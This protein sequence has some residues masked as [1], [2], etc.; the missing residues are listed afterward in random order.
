[1]GG[2]QA[3]AWTPG[4][5]SFP[6]R[7]PC[8][9]VCSWAAGRRISDLQIF[10]N[11]QIV[12]SY[13]PQ[14]FMQVFSLA[15]RRSLCYEYNFCSCSLWEF[16]AWIRADNIFFVFHLPSSLE[17]GI[18]APPTSRK[19]K[20]GKAENDPREPSE[21]GRRFGSSCVERFLY[22]LGG[23]LLLW[24]REFFDERGFLFW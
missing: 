13:L 10:F 2:V 9:C 6:G 8:A 17:D 4:R 24:R 5:S 22:D 15:E 7:R 20:C 19:K 1:M 3:P 21:E 23:F 11:R 18:D 14:F 12:P 16:L